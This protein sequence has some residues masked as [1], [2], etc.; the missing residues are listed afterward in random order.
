MTKHPEAVSL[1]IFYVHEQGPTIGQ[2][3]CNFLVF[4]LRFR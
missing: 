3:R 4:D 2:F 1:E